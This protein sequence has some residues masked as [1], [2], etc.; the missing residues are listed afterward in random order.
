MLYPGDY[1]AQV[2]DENGN[3]VANESFKVTS[4]STIVVVTFG[5]EKKAQSYLYDILIVPTTLKVGNNT[6]DV[7]FSSNTYSKG[8][9]KVYLEVPEGWKTEKVKLGEIN[10]KNHVQLPVEVPSTAYG[11]YILTLHVDTTFGKFNKSFAVTA[12]GTAPATT[13]TPASTP[14]PTSTPMPTATPILTPSPTPTPTQT[15]AAT[16]TPTTPTTP[17]TTN[18]T[19]IGNKTVSPTPEPVASP[20]FEVLLAV[21]AFLAVLGLR[22]RMR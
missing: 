1:Y 12:E 18:E 5:E 4:T 9:A 21:L 20:G 8:G 6:L 2:L 14:T 10:F 19:G 13:P 17:T 16:A 22:P 7:F 15:P 11:S 3:E